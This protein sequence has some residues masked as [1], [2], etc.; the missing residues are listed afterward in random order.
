MLEGILSTQS[1]I[2]AKKQFIKTGRLNRKIIKDEIAL[3]WYRC[4]LNNLDI[5]QTLKN[6]SV[7]FAFVYKI[8]QEAIESILKTINRESYN[9]F[10]ID[11][12]G[13]VLGKIV[14]DHIFESLKNMQEQFIGTNAGALAL[15]THKNETVIFHEHYLN[16]LSHYCSY[17]IPIRKEDELLAI[18]VIYVSHQLSDLEKHQILEIIQKKNKM[19]SGAL[20]S[21][22]NEDVDIS[23]SY[24]LDKLFLT[25]S[26]KSKDLMNM[27]DQYIRI[28]MPI[29]L[30]GSKNSGKTALGWYIAY[31]QT[32]A[33]CYID[34]KNIPKVLRMH[35][36]EK[37]MSQNETVILDNL[38]CGDQEIYKLLTVYTEEKL[39]KKNTDKYSDYRCRNIILITVYSPKELKET[40]HI[41]DRFL[42]R[43]CQQ[44]IFVDD[45]VVNILTEDTLSEVLKRYQYEFSMDYMKMLLKIAVNRNIGDV[46]EMIEKSVVSK[47]KG[48]LIVA[49]DLVL[50]DEVTLE[51]LAEKEKKYILEV[52]HKMNENITLTAE[53][54][55]IGRSTLYRKLQMYQKDTK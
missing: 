18:L 42:A 40:I 35:W 32:T 41:T 50:K 22:Q 53:V 11:A 21:T 27:I 16:N 2:D 46:I 14:Y 51:T 17:S 44:V 54:L 29:Y 5:N 47:P 13:N 6:E 33:S 12:E 31:K 39:I 4:R 52:Y 48:S 34:I 30:H 10:I 19:H 7:D 24:Q 38:E 23:M 28:G 49:S 37:Q 9:T 20:Y 1:I 45:Y 43:L 15:K 8:D 55:N 26:Y 36:I 25:Q 3:S